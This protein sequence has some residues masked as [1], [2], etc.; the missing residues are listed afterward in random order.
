MFSFLHKCYAKMGIE[1]VLPRE[2][3]VTLTTAT[4]NKPFALSAA[5]AEEQEVRG[6]RVPE[7]AAL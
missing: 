6:G 2:E 3:Q 1:G 4:A 5:E 7:E